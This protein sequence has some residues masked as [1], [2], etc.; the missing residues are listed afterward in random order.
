VYDV[1]LAKQNYI[2]GDQFTL[3]DVYHLPYGKM[4]NDLGYKETFEKY[5]NVWA[6]WERITGRESWKN[7]AAGNV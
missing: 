3:A 5:P 1:I 4:A 2:A 7:V 6:W